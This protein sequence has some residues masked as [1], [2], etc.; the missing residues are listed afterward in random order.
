MNYITELLPDMQINAPGAT[1]TLH[2]RMLRL[3]VQDFLRESEVWLHELPVIYSVEGVDRYALP[4]PKHTRIARVGWAKLDGR[5][6]T[7]IEAEDVAENRAPGYLITNDEPH[8]LRVS[9]RTKRGEIKVSVTLYPTLALDELPDWLIH[10]FRTA[11]V[12]SGLYKLYSAPGSPE[13][14][15]NFA[16]YHAAQVEQVILRGKRITSNRKTGTHRT[17]RYGGY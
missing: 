16:Q 5:D 12:S 8:Q 17:V 2:T 11:L 13:Y 15:L 10:D 9:E 1:P 4:L 6:L 14:D 3:G 7:P